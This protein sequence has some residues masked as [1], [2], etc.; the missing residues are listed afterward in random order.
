MFERA[1]CGT[2]GGSAPSLVLVT[3][4][5]GLAWCV[6]TCRNAGRDDDRHLL[7]D[8]RR[9]VGQVPETA[10]LLCTWRYSHRTRYNSGLLVDT[11]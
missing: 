2:W 8:L 1:I 3:E 6:Y 9:R 4:Q 5:G 10:P 11:S 7:H